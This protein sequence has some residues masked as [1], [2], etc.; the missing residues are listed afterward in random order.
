MTRVFLLLF[1]GLVLSGFSSQPITQPKD[2]RQAQNVLPQSQ[3]DMWKI[4][5]KC[6]VRAD[7]KTYRYSIRYTPE[8]KALEGKKLTISGFM[9][10]LES[11]EKF[12][13]FLLS[14][15]TPTCP[16]CPPGEPNEIVEV[17]TTQP[18][19]WDEGIMVIDGTLRFTRNPELGLFFQ[20]KNAA[21]VD[22]K[23][24]KQNKLPGA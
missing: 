14:K 16:F 22:I 3:D 10:P 11:S 23:V 1:L 6:K 20:L 2:E 9:L 24:P 12:T 18:V 21:T 8:V 5:G 7:T 13:H 15:R 19:T 17:F 4:F